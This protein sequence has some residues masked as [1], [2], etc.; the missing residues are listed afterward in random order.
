MCESTNTNTNTNT[1]VKCTS[2]SVLC[3]RAVWTAAVKLGAVC[4]LKTF[5]TDF[6][7]V[8]CTY[9]KRKGRKKSKANSLKVHSYV[10]GF[11]DIFQNFKAYADFL[12][13]RPG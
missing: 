2:A 5:L 9:I 11:E 4:F 12:T 1:N 6:F 13:I 10:H 8:K 3:G 7:C